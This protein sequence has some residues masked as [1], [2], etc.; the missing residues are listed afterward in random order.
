MF[1]VTV[2]ILPKC[3]RGIRLQIHSGH[4][5][6]SLASLISKKK[7]EE[8]PRGGEGREGRKEERGAVVTGEGGEEGG[9]GR[10]RGQRESIAK[11]SLAPLEHECQ[12]YV[13]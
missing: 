4:G 9:E 2:R 5:T 7:K 10:A 1:N 8:E 11:E 6:Y 13:L 12:I 3:R